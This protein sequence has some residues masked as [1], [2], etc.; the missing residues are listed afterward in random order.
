MILLRS[1]KTTDTKVI[2]IEEEAKL[3]R[4]ISSS[5]SRPPGT[6][7]SLSINWVLEKD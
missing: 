4:V 6:R 3:V 5:P 7:K 1:E 2:L